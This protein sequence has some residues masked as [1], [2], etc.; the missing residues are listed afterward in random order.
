MAMDAIR[1]HPTDNVAVATRE[2]EIGETVQAAD[3]SLIAKEKIP[4]GHKVALEEI[5]AGNEVRKYGEV[6]GRAG[7][8]IAAGELVHTHNL[9]FEEE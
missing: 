8:N 7:E 3:A 6:I 9:R 1:V 4:F 5:P 2:I